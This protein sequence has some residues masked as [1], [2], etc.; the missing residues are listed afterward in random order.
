MTSTVVG[1]RLTAAIGSDD[2]RFILLRKLSTA[3]TVIA[4]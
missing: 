1:G 2:N 3:R 4:S